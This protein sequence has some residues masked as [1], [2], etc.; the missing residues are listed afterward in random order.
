MGLITARIAPIYACLPIAAA[1]GLCAQQPPDPTARLLRLRQALAERDKRLP[2]YTCVQTVD[3][4]YFRRR[5]AQ[6][7]HLSCE[8]LSGLGGK[9]LV[10]DSTDRLR[11]DIKVSRGVE[12]GS[13]PGSQFTARNIF[14]LIGGGAYGTGMLGALILDIFVNGA[15]TYRYKGETT[16]SGIRLSAYGYR[17][18]EDASHYKVRAGSHWIP[19]AFSGE[20]WLDS[21]SLDL[22]RLTE[23]ATALPPETGA[24]EVDSTAD[25]QKVE[26]GQRAFLL[27]RDSS[28]RIKM[29]DARETQIDA[30][31]AGCREYRGEA[32]IHFGDVSAGGETPGDDAPGPPLPEGLPL[33]V[34]LT[35]PI[36]TGTAAAGDIVQARLR[37]AVR[38]PQ[39]KS[40]L[41]PKG[42]AV[43]GRILRMRHWLRKPARYTIDV[44]LET[45]E[46]AGARRPLYAEP[47]RHRNRPG[48][49][50]V[51][52][53][54]MRQ[55]P[56][57]AIFTIVTDKRRY[58][59]PAGFESE[60][61]T[62]A[63]R[64]EED[65]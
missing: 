38:D 49:M 14:E 33:T 24:C 23:Q 11:L 37:H 28:I 21:S 15:A 61:I 48:P 44:S 12:I 30:V 29:R 42:A 4:E 63:P 31:Y 19:V 34:V 58:R 55:S 5:H 18:P 64:M 36:N 45:L 27:P 9:D 65:Q 53:P 13:W 62:A 2:D 25:Y 47:L 26:V 17:V 57:R 22:K 3:R 50:Y 10:L 1:A 46:F 60:W 20:F 43:Q 16:E 52:I 59:V 56:P 40:I 6:D 39:S 54:M 7:Q 8:Q 32:T 41:A 51:A 35:E